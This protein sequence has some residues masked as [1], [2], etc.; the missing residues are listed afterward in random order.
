M[1][2]G[3]NPVVGALSFAGDRLRRLAPRL[4]RGDVDDRDPD[5]IRELLPGLWLLIGAWFR[6][7]VR[8][9]HHLPEDGPALIVGNH[10]GGIMSP[11]VLIS[12]LAITSY[13]G[14]ERPFYQLA[15]RMVLNSPL[16]PILRR[17][18]TVEADP[19]N[20]HAVLEQ[21]GLLQVFPGGDYEVYRPTSQSG[22]IDFGGRKGFLRLALRHDVPIVPQVTIGGQETALFLSR[23]EKIA[24]FLRLDRALR[25]KVLPVML[26]APFGITVPFAPFLPLPSKIVIAYLP[27]IHLRETYGDDPDLDRVYDDLV[28]TMQD[29]LSSLQA[30]RKLP[31]IG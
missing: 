15:H 28:A 22:L 30:E 18:G 20:G 3:D 12:Q 1:D 13:C 4:R 8:G 19:D 31:V 7:D 10:T 9:L 24:E 17:F 29:V 6:P 21:G 25:L 23:G 14:V 26:S 2:L 11:E 27:P 16:A 5:A